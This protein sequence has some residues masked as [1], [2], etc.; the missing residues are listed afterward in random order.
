[1]PGVARPWTKRQKISCGRLAA[2]AASAVATVSDPDR[3][4]DDAAQPDPIGEAA[5]ERRGERDRDRRR[6]DRQADV[7]GVASKLRASSG[8]SGWVA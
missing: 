7:E 1:M 5:D 4:D 3:A 8:S 6:G 2:V